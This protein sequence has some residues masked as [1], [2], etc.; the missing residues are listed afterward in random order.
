MIASIST[1]ARDRKRR[2]ACQQSG[3]HSKRPMSTISSAEAYFR[4]MQDGN[5]PASL[6]SF[7]THVLNPFSAA[8]ELLLV[9]LSGVPSAGR[10]NDA[11]GVINGL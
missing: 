11:I 4:S 2:R 3:F 5:E 10:A 7:G 8:T 1:H 6:S 9:K